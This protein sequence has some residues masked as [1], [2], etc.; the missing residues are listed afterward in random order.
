MNGAENKN[1]GKPLAPEEYRR[2][3][4]FMVLL[5]VAKWKSVH[6]PIRISPAWILAPTLS[7]GSTSLLSQT[8]METLR[9]DR[10]DSEQ[11]YLEQFVISENSDYRDMSNFNVED[12]LVD[13]LK[14]NVV[15]LVDLDRK[16]MENLQKPYNERFIVTD[17]VVCA[18]RT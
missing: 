1:F 5:K 4:L 9:D 11:S 18:I 13:S 14:E 8:R 12:F 15:S 10:Y 17:G 3:G 7:I 6:S 2:Q 16:H